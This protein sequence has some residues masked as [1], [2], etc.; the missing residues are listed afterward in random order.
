[1]MSDRQKIAIVKIDMLR[2]RGC[3]LCFWMVRRFLSIFLWFFGL[4]GLETNGFQF[5]EKKNQNASHFASRTRTL[6]NTK[7]NQT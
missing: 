6:K 2:Y 5:L 7:K 4:V 1:M 3:F